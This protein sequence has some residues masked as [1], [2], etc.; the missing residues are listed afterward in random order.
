MGFRTR[1]SRINTHNPLPAPERNEYVELA[2]G[3]VREVLEVY[4]R[5]DGK[6]P[7]PSKVQELMMVLQIEVERRYKPKIRTVEPEREIVLKDATLG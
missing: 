2:P 5:W 3:F 7:V 4:D 1:H 6:D